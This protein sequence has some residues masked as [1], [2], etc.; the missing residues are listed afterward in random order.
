MTGASSN[1]SQSHSK[2]AVISI[3]DT[4]KQDKHVEETP[5]LKFSTSK[6]DALNNEN[7]VKSDILVVLY[8]TKN[9]NQIKKL[10]N[11][12]HGKKLGNIEEEAKRAKAQ[13]TALLK[14]RQ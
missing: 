5:P 10:I 7:S 9:M 4:E 1:R 12:K 6:Q 11:K 3:D 2:S 13:L 8:K 14:V